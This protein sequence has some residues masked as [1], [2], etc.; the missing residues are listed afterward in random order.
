MFGLRPNLM[1]FESSLLFF[2]PGL[3]LTNQ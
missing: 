2:P 3:S 1:V